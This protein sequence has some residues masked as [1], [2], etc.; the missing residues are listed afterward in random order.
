MTRRHDSES[1]AAAVELA[2]VTM[3]VLLPILAGVVDVGSAL[4]IKAQLDE[5]AAEG[6]SAAAHA[7]TEHPAAQQRAVD[8]VSV[9]TLTPADVA[10]SCQGARRV[11][12]TV[13]YDYSPIFVSFFGVDDFEIEATNVS[14]VLSGDDCA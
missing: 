5:A 10:I 4:M 14:D 6:S 8:S 2:L 11:A 3:F 7:P 13:T 9:V 1:G 12:A